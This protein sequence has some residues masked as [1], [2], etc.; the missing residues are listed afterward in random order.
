MHA[1]ERLNALG[2]ASGSAQLAAQALS[3]LKRALAG[4]Q[5]RPSQ[6][7]ALTRQAELFGRFAAA[8]TKDA[9]ALAATLAQEGPWPFRNLNEVS[10][11]FPGVG[12]DDGAVKDARDFLMHLAQEPQPSIGEA[13]QRNAKRVFDLCQQW[14]TAQLD[15]LG[16]AVRDN[17]DE[18]A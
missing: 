13:E 4:K 7:L 8:K 15:L 14:L 16:S 3:G 18:E 5:I 10:E 1:D 2:Q 9:A 11:Q 12:V 17:F 6:R